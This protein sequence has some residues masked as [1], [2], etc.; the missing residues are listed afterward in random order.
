MPAAAQIGQLRLVATPLGIKEQ[1]CFRLE[2]GL[3][4]RGVG[5]AEVRAKVAE[6]DTR[7]PSPRRSASR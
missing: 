3:A 7:Q 1:T 6:S 4:C 2:I 5:P